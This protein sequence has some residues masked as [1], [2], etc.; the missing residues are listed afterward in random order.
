MFAKLAKEK[1]A[2]KKQAFDSLI[3]GYWIFFPIPYCLMPSALLTIA[4]LLDI[5]Y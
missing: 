5:G 3:I 2:H 1:N 4:M